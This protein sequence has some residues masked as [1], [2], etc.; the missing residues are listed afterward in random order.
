[1]A[2]TAY[3]DKLAARVEHHA[4]AILRASGSALRNYS[5]AATRAA[6]FAAVM[7]AMRT[8]AELSTL[9]KDTDA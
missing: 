4:D 2:D 5:M 8:G 6:I 1:M 7:D 3:T 9:T